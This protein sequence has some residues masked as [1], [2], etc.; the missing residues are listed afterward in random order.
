MEFL[1]PL[2]VENKPNRYIYQ[3]IWWCSE[4]IEAVC[5]EIVHCEAW[6]NP[7]SVRE[8]V[9]SAISLVRHYST[10]FVRGHILGISDNFYESK[11]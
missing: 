1:A 5:Q 10:Y 7:E 8:C 11:K 6:L 2:H 4:Q 3:F 9:D